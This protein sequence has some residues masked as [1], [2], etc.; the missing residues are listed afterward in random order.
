[1]ARGSAKPRFP[2]ASVMQITSLFAVALRGERTGA[3]A[4]ASAAAALVR[5]AAEPWL[6]VVVQVAAVRKVQPL[7]AT[8]EL[9]HAGAEMGASAC[10]TA[11]RPTAAEALIS[12]AAGSAPKPWQG[13]G[14]F[15]PG[16]P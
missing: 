10:A 2:G 4:R 14:P 8:W 15:V 13:H 6:A 9:P 11:R 12:W 16:S 1:M 5:P 7:A 3:I